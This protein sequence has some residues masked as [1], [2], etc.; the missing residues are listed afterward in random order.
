[1]TTEPVQAPEP[2]DDYVPNPTQW[3]R[4][5][6]ELYERSGGTEGTETHGIPII[7]MTYRGRRTGNRYKTPVIRVEHDG[8][9][10]AVASL[11]GS[12]KNPAW[13]HNLLA[14]PNVVVRD[15]TVVFDMVARE[16][17]GEERE[18]WWRRAVEVLPYYTDYQAKTTRRI[19]VLVLEPVDPA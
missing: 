3:I 12:P 1:M 5:Q 18:N 7:L 11:G 10:A 9:Y 6:V 14:H 19:P 15:R 2:V 16:A 13:Y 4:E 17:E 8:V